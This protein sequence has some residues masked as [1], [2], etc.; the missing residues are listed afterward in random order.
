[1]SLIHE[2]VKHNQE[3]DNAPTTDP[4]K[5]WLRIQRSLAETSEIALCTLLNDN[6]VTG[7]IEND[8][9]I[10]QM[11]QNELPYAKLCQKD[12]GTAYR[13]AVSAKGTIVYRCHASLHCFA[14]VV[15]AGERPLVVLGGR[16]FT[17]MADYSEFLADYADV[18][19]VQNGECLKNV[20]FS[21]DRELADVA[22]LVTTTA[23]QQPYGLVSQSAAAPADPETTPELLDA[24]LEIIRLSDELQSTNR[25]FQEFQEFFRSVTTNLDSEMIYTDA[26]SKFSEIMKAERS[27]LMVLDEASNELA[28]EAAVGADL[29]SKNRIRMK[30]G[31]EISGA[32]LAAGLPFL[33]RDIDTDRRVRRGNREG[34]KSKSFISYPIILGRKKIGVINLTDRIGGSSYETK[35]VTMLDMIAPQLALIIERTELHKKA[36]R[37]Q[38]MSLTDPLTGLPNRRY[39]EE[40]LFEEIER[41]K[42]HNSTLCF[43][44]LD[45][46]NF[47]TLNDQYGHSNADRVLVKTAA[48]V[49]RSVRAIDRPARYA[50]DE[51]CVIL[52]ETELHAAALAAERLCREVRQTEYLTEQG[53][54]I[55]GVTVSIG[56][57]SFSRTRHSPNAI[58][59][60][61]DRALYQA[62]AQGR[63]RVSVYDEVLSE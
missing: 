40:R 10:C 56:V 32:V 54:G 47:K 31:D 52:P 22:E 16:A 6:Q 14:S 48:L 37:Y 43:L 17:S 3:S 23:K 53:E 61:A 4:V 63:N 12:C 35:D 44:L 2:K 1:M 50:G 13:R 27:S 7:R 55:G 41:C 38:R 9:S 49:Q 46:D 21:D 29:A 28:L 59:E 19:K 11:M 58:F 15:Q 62:K 34:Y 25:A 36:E 24:H 18:A 51:F 30:L 60:S 42:R 26:L 33:V 57:S 20:L 8:N 39:L 5:G 45:I